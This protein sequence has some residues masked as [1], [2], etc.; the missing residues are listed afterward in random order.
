[1]MNINITLDSNPH[2]EPHILSRKIIIRFTYTYNL[3]KCV[4]K[5]RK[6]KSGSIMILINKN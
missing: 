4:S 6:S 2:P 3:H 1:M 5:R